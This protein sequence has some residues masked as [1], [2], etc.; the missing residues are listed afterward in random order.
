LG[1]KRRKIV[2]VPE[3]EKIAVVFDQ[4]VPAADE[5]SAVAQAYRR[6]FAWR[7][8]IK[9]FRGVGPERGGSDPRK[10][11]DNSAGGRSQIR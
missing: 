4:M 8:G 9:R 10:A 11:S 6:D 7:F 5:R 1:R 2:H 3:S